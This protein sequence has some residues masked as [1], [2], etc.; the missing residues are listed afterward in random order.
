MRRIYESDAL[1]RDDGEP[2]SPNERERDSKPR[3]I[4]SFDT[5]VLTR[6]FLPEW[7]VNRGISVS[8]DVPK[9]EFTVGDT[10]PFLVTM[11]NSMPFAVALRARSPVLWQWQLDGL[12]EASHFEPERPD[13]TRV[14]S[15][16]RGERKQFRKRWNG[17]IQISEHEWERA[18][19]GEYTLSAGINVD[20]AQKKG[21][22][23]EL[24]IRLVEDA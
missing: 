15:F 20:D 5:G 17:M 4:R 19:P 6:R 16:S 1:E 21:L 23:D 7:L 9:T 18:T 8:I 14:F 2:F 3:A 11:R 22:S 12:V 24:T 10:V 13:E